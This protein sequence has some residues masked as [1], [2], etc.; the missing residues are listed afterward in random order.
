M[1]GRARPNDF[2]SLI[3]ALGWMFPTPVLEP[4][5]IK[6]PHS[7]EEVQKGKPVVKSQHHHNDYHSSRDSGDVETPKTGASLTRARKLEH[8]L[9]PTQRTA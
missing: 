8:L 4:Q 7:E 2:A 9:S 6:V 3:G 5:H 1:P